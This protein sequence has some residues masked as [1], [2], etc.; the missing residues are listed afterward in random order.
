MK[1]SF[2]KKINISRPI[3]EFYIIDDEKRRFFLNRPEVQDEIKKA[4]EISY[5]EGFEK[6][7]LEGAKKVEDQL[8]EEINTVA[9]AFNNAITEI[10]TGKKKLVEEL[11][12]QIVDLA[13]KAAET[14]IGREI[15]EKS[16]DLEKIIKPILAKVPDATRIIIRINPDDLNQMR[17]FSNDLVAEGGIESL[18]IVGDINVSRGGCVIDTDV[19]I[20]DASIET[21][22][23]Q[24]KES[25]SGKPEGA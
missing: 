15:E 14:V 19:G 23:E 3:K 2:N 21:R 24:M 8:K 7:T 6:G 11:E 20:I 1:L 12:P 18:E 10:E 13:L 5:K 9:Q 16:A 22:V 4:R 17:E 25:V